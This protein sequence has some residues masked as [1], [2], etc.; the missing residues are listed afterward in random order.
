LV[1]VERVL[2]DYKESGALNA[3]VN[4][5]A[6]IDEQTFLTKSGEL[7]TFLKVTG[8][9]AECLEPME[10][11]QIVRRFGSALR[12][13][14]ERYRIYQ[15][16]IKRDYG[17]IPHESSNHPVTRKA[18]TD[19]IDSLEAKGLYRL[20]IFYVIVHGALRSNSN[21]LSRL[22][23][24]ITDP[25]A[26]L[27]AALLTE[28][29]IA[30]LEEDIDR[31]RHELA[32]KVQNFTTQLRDFVAIAVLNKNGA[33]RFVRGL[34]NY[35]SHKAE[36]PGLAYDQYVD[37]QACSSALECHRDH[38]RL[39][40]DFVEVLTLKEPPAQTHAHLLK[41]LQELPA[42]FVAVTEWKRASHHAMRRLIQS[43]RRHFHNSKASLVN[44]LGS[45]DVKPKDMLID[46]SASALVNELGASLEDIEVKGGFL[47]EFSLSIV[48]YD[49]DH[50]R[51]RRSVAECFK[52]FS[53]I[54]AQL[55]EERYNLLNAYL[56]TL[57]ANHAFNLR[58]MWITN[59]NY[60]DFAFLFA[61]YVGELRNAH[62]G[63]EYLT[64]FETNHRTPYFFNLHHSDIAHLFML[65]ATGSGK[66]F[67][68][69]FI[70][71]HLQKFIPFTYIFDLGGS[72]QG[73][74]Q[75]FGGTYVH[76]GKTDSSLRIN[77]FTLPLTAD[78]LQFQCSLVRVLAES[79]GYALTEADQREL[80]NQIENLYAVEPGQRRLLTLA[81]ILPRNLRQALG[82]W[83]EGG[84][85]GSV[86]DNVEDTLTLARFQTFDFEG[87]DQVPQ[88]MEPLLFYVLHRSQSVIYNEEQ[89]GT[90]KVFVVDEAWRFLR[91]PV[92]RCYVQEALKTWR[93]KNAAMIL[94]TQSGDDLLRS[95]M[96]PVIV[97]SCATQLYLANPGMDLAAYR[98]AFHLSETE[99]EMIASL[100][101]KRQFLLKRPNFAKVLNLDLERSRP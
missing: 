26:A 72:Y 32:H 94:A 66:S 74:T 57:P 71:T 41:A 35:A 67:T 7:V 76:L 21:L 80:F 83:V 79:S 4:L 97:E 88:V 65:G 9:D 96:L 75:R 77:P 29:K 53:A 16:L 5:H 92:I 19:R 62:L 95:E 3:L 30:L 11:D 87:M 98:Q 48:L 18:V 17:Q 56:A 86:F 43:K 38:L 45:A 46:D 63:T 50:L 55:T 15:Y 42:P 70:L 2:K 47:G 84:Q 59:A 69:V 1:K 20:E 64:I 40:D 49:R 58:K 31:A 39:D 10:L 91:N 54:D 51:L 73:L 36:G 81:S 37:F 22:R 82:K 100:I 85:Y 12:V 68:L 61:P 23:S 34:L 101:P 27:R 89:A 28:R 52:V 6:A 33:F 24:W 44:Y 60:S 25:G 93:K 8:A 14:D 99:A 90:F 78:N 13:F